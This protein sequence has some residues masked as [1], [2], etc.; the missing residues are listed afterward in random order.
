MNASTILTQL[1]R[2][3]RLFDEA[4]ASVPAPQTNNGVKIMERQLFSPADICRYVVFFGVG[5]G[6][7]QVVKETK[8]RPIAEIEA[9]RKEVA[10]T[11]QAVEVRDAE[12][13]TVVIYLGRSR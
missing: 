10:Q 2:K 1:G 7:R 11:A 5:D 12:S 13:T 8:W 6:K 3:L 9:L 4:P